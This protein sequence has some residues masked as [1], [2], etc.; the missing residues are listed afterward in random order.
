MKLR[1]RVLPVVFILVALSFSPSTPGQGTKKPAGGTA[2][3]IYGAG[4][5]LYDSG[6]YEKAI[7][8]Y[9][10]AIHL[11][12]DFEES[13]Y[14]LGMAYSS[15]GRYKEAVEA[16][17]RAVRLKPDYAAVYENLGHAFS[18]LAQYEKAI[19]AFRKAIE[20]AP[21][22]IEPYF[23]L[24]NAYFNS[25]KE[26]EAINT[27]E[28]AIQR[29]PDDPYAY[30]NLGLLYLRWGS[31]A[32]AVD[33]F[34]QAIIRDPRY[35][36]AYF[37]RA[38]AYLILGRGESVAGD[39]ETYMGLKGWRAEHSLDLAVVAYFGYL[40]ARQEEAARKVLDDAVRQG[41]TEAWPYP[42][43]E[44]LMQKIS[45]QLL[46]KTAPDQAKKIEARAYIGMNLALQGDQ[47]AALEHL[48]WVAGHS[49][50]WSLTLGLALSGMDRIKATSAVTSKR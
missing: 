1:N 30:Y 23:A 49:D 6:E 44:Y 3:E 37:N 12:P 21:D 41:N 15:L 28:A 34:S 45:A 42:V 11:N 31:P 47:K 5:A 38:C 29:K 16:Y 25:G 2:E 9:K 27:Y 33:A 39:A 46:F 4:V 48:K 43:I 8:A 18:N 14:R 17:N 50:E 35:A 40:Q 24:G 22:N 13:Y 10:R 36:E 26:E 19:K 20:L 7:E 32:R